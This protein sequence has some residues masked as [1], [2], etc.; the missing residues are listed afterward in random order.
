MKRVFLA[1]GLAILLSGCAAG[2]RSQSEVAVYDLGPLD[3]GVGRDPAFADV[4]LEIG[5][6]EWLD[7]SA[8]LYRLDYA[9][10][11]RIRAYAQARW[12]ASPKLMLQRRLRQQLGLLPGASR[13]TLRV[14]VHEFGQ[15]F[16]SAR[17]SDVLVRGEALLI[18]RGGVLHGR[19]ALE[20]RQAAPGADAAGGAAALA[21]VG[22]RLAVT[23]GDWL[24]SRDLSVCRKAG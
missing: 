16:S 22:E 19:H 23:L 3:E 1:L 14:E 5:L 13:C 11:R 8:M 15:R 12:A 6:P 24:R 4:A 18:A 20:M 10:S 17:H 21:I 7:T 2:G 9:D